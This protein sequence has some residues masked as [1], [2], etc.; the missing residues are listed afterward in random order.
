V[1]CLG[2]G[3]GAI[4]R[5]KEG[6]NRW[7]VGMAQTPDEKTYVEIPFVEQ[8]TRMGW[9]HIEGDIGNADLIRSQFYRYKL[10]PIPPV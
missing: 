6:N 2:R 5:K 3:P 8:L 4:W 10:I 1:E 7:Q 9:D